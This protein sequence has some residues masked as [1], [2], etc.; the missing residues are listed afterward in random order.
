MRWDQGRKLMFVLQQMHWFSD[1]GSGKLFANGVLSG[2]WR[3]LS[4]SPHG[5]KYHCPVEVAL[6]LSAGCMWP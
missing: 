2:V 5:K 4:M 1:L 3:C 6:L